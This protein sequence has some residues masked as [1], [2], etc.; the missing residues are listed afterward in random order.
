MLTERNVVVDL[1]INFV[2]K[3]KNG[4]K[5]GNRQSFMYGV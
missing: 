1:K 2:L 3:V 5:R 4:N